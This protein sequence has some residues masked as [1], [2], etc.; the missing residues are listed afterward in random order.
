MVRPCVASRNLRYG[1]WSR[2][3][4]SGLDLAFSAPSHHVYQRIVA[5]FSGQ[6]A[7]GP[8]G[9]PGFGDAG[10]TVFSICYGNSQTLSGSCLTWLREAIPSVILKRLWLRC[11]TFKPCKKIVL[12][13]QDRPGDAGEFVGKR[14]G[15]DFVM[16]SFLGSFRPCR[17]QLIGLIRTTQATSTKSFRR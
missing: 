17:S 14:D 7:D 11:M 6:A 3:N 2:I 15:E 9:S 16:E 8:F 5:T 13:D 10:K 1:N 4:A 12:A